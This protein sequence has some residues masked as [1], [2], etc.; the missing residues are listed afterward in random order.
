MVPRQAIFSAD[1]EERVYVKNGD[2]FAARTVKV[3]VR[4][5][6]TVVVEEGLQAG[7]VVALREPADAANGDEV[8]PTETEPVS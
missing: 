7:D 1:G 8:S 3:G 2:G 5:M 6:G 4:S